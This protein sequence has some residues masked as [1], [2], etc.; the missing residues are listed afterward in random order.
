MLLRRGC[1]RD[2]VGGS[3]VGGVGT[4]AAA[5]IGGCDVAGALTVGVDAAVVGTS[6]RCRAVGG[7]AVAAAYPGHRGIVPL[8][9]GVGGR[10][11]DVGAGDVAGGGGAAAAVIVSGP[12][13]GAGAVVGAG[14]GGGA[15]AA[16]AERGAAVAAM[17]GGGA[18]SDAGGSAVAGGGADAGAGA[19][20]VADVGGGGGARAVA[21]AAGAAVAVGAGGGAVGGVGAGGGAEVTSDVVV[22]AVVGAVRVAAGAVGG[23]SGCRVAGAVASRS[24]SLSVTSRIALATADSRDMEPSGPEGPGGW[25]LSRFSV[26]SDQ[27]EVWDQGAR[28][29]GRE[30]GRG[31]SGWGRDQDVA[32]SESL[33]DPGHRRRG[34]R[35]DEDDVDRREGLSRG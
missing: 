20:G 11:A 5:V 25:T 27:A 24:D 22:G 18:V 14:G 34:W 28:S 6:G 16:A 8:K 32:A 33:D 13:A 29:V 3:G 1:R 30:G 23:C 7:G 9:D 10:V 12:A 19:D 4:G 21:V 31:R 26:G 17:V 15:V 2:D 35:V